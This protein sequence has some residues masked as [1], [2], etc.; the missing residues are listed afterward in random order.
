ML[1][2][3]L[4]IPSTTSVTTSSSSVTATA[5]V[6]RSETTNSNVVNPAHPNRYRA[7]VEPSTSAG[8]GLAYRVSNAQSAS[9]NAPY[10]PNTAA[11]NVL[12]VRNSNIPARNWATP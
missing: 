3:L 1:P 12:P 8:M 4:P 11:P 6:V 5:A 10:E 7:S 9:Q 2:A